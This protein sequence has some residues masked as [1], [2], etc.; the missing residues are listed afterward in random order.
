M[1]AAAQQI[2]HNLYALPFT[3]DKR[4]VIALAIELDDKGRG[5]INW[6]KVEQ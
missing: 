6:E 2:A 5:L 4:E 3:A 1:K